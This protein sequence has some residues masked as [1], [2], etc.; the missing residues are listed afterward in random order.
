MKFR[1]DAVA[2]AIATG[3]FILTSVTPAEAA[4]ITRT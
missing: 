2:F 4:T 3:L 1:F